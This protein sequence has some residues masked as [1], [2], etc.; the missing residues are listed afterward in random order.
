MP[1]LIIPLALS[2]PV[3]WALPLVYSRSAVARS[4][5]LPAGYSRIHLRVRPVGAD[6]ISV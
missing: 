4:I 5:R 6:W 1:G 3:S 2:S